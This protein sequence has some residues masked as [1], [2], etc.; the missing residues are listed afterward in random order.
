MR[1]QL[2]H[3]LATHVGEVLTLDLA[4]QIVREVLNATDQ[5]LEPARFGQDV[6]GRYTIQAEYLLAAMPELARHHAAYHREVNPDGPALD[7]DYPRALDRARA[8]EAL[9]V[10]G[11][12]DGRM[13]ASLLVFFNRRIDTQ[14][15]VAQDDRMF[16]DPEHRGGMLAARLW[17]FAQRAGLSLGI[18][19]GWIESR[20]DNRA[21]RLAEFMGYRPVATKYVMTAAQDACGPEVPTR[22]STGARNEPLAQD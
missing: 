16:I 15:L 6:S 9:L 20:G 1:S 13:V 4:K 21:G 22:H 11:R 19:E 2:A 17:R 12:A 10:T 14:T 7:Y 18:R 8:G 5:S 3:S